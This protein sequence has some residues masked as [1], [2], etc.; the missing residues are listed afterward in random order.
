MID[1]LN[2]ARAAFVAVNAAIFVWS[3][4][5]LSRYRL[6][7]N[8]KK[9]SSSSS[10]PKSALLIIAHPD[11]E[12]MFFLPTL[13]ALRSRSRKTHLLCLSSS[14]SARL[15]ELGQSCAALGIASWR[16]G[17]L[18]DGP[19]HCW[20]TEE[21]ARMVAEAVARIPRVRAVLTFDE[22]GVSGHPNHAACAAGC[23][24][25]AERRDKEGPRL[26][27]LHTV[28]IVRKYLGM[29]EAGATAM[30]SS[31]NVF[32]FSFD[33]LATWNRMSHSYPSQFVWYR[34]LFVL[35]SR[36]TFINTYTVIE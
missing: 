3:M 22:G 11:D 24:L 4:L 28:G 2:Y 36:Y 26:L 35:F 9:K 30:L 8:N 21:V 13:L 14:S 10:P 20:A 16:S 5:S 34:K 15:R 25:W 31:S 1:W 33:P 12:A 32:F 7:R 27:M 23:R 19:Q 18:P 17:V 6:S 29:L